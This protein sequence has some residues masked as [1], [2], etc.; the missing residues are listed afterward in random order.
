M[1]NNA[2]ILAAGS[3][4]APEGVESLQDQLNVNATGLLN[5]SRAFAPVL[6]QNGGGAIVN[7]LSVLSWLS[8]EYTGAYSASKAAARAITNAL[9]LE[10]KPQHTHV[11]AVHPGM[12]DTDMSASLDVPKMSTLE[13]ATA[14]YAALQRDESE[15]VLSEAGAWVKQNLSS[16][17]PP[18]LA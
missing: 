14:I 2:G 12:V 11:L 17:T 16:A 7:V 5:L 10:L 13:V 4:L 9:R 3:L 15:L 8:L 1:I 18:Y 6:K